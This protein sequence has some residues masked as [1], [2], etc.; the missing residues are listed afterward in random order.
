MKS[1]PNL[2]TIKFKCNLKLSP[3][4]EEK[5]Y[6]DIEK[7]RAIFFK[8]SLIGEYSTK[9][10]SFGNIS[11]RLSGSNEFIITGAQTGQFPNLTGAQYTK[12][13]K[14]D[15]KKLSLDAIGPTAPS[16]E[17]VTHYSIYEKCTQV[18]A[19]FHVHH[20]ELWSFLNKNQCDSI[21]KDVKHGTQEMGL[22]CG[23]CIGTKSKG[24]MVLE[25][26]QDGII[27]FGETIEDAGKIIL[28]TLKEARK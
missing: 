8:M 9:K 27:S 5:L 22:A 28:E 25:G 6:I 4:L 3:E 7:W 23:D 13:V 1:G 18:N 26:H 16:A 11:K 21:A 15:L 2:G 12:V 14:C 24:I 20:T 10:I 19:I 17:S